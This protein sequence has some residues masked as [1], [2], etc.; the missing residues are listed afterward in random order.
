MKYDQYAQIDIK[1]KREDKQ[2]QNEL[3]SPE[4]V[5]SLRNQ[6][7]YELRSEVKDQVRADLQHQVEKEM[8]AK[9]RQ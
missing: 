9:V 4:Q 1:P 7:R 3:M 2:I 5:S 8:E 6:I